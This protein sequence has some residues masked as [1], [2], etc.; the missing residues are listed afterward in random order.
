MAP[1]PFQ[2]PGNWAELFTR[3]EKYRK[4]FRAPVDTIGCH[5]L[6]DPNAPRS[7]QRFQT[8]IALMLSS[9]T[10]DEVTA[11]AMNSL[12]RKL[13][14]LISKVGFHNN[15]TKYIKSVVEILLDKYDGAPP[16]T[17]EELVLLPGVGPKMAHLFLQAADQHV[18]GI[19]VDT[20]V[21]RIAR[22]F[23]WVPATTKTPEDTRKVLESWLKKTLG[24]NKRIDC[25][26]RPDGMLPVNPRCCE[27]NLQDVCPNA[28]QK[29]LERAPSL[30]SSGSFTKTLKTALHLPRKKTKTTRL[31]ARVMLIEVGP[32][33]SHI[34]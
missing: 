31:S 1:K 15:K 10:K 24:N 23:R 25:G 28:F 12:I 7:I 34:K 22:R 6:H 3:L 16:V 5:C 21:H 8:L 14:R 19:G 11:E 29:V 30:G 32:L 20:H 27:C 2:P 13:N 17:Y 33:V 4:T 26:T 18:V 9:Q